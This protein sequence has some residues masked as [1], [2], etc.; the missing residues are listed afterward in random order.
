M[1]EACADCLLVITLSVAFDI[2]PYVTF[3]ILSYDIL[4]QNL[5]NNVYW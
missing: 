1:F 5:V 2:L 3:D 4:Y